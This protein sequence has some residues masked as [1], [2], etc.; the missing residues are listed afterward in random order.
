MTTYRVSRA[1]TLRLGDGAINVFD[2]Y[3]AKW[4]KTEAGG[5][6]LGRVYASGIVIELA[7]APTAADRA[8]AF[9]FDRSTRF[10]QAHVNKAWN[11]S[12]GEQIYLGEWHSHPTP[13]AKPS[14]RD[15][16]MIFNNLREARMEIDFLF[17]IVVGWAKDWVGIAKG[18]SL[19]Q[20]VRI[21]A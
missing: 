12:G 18:R 6:L 20:L 16:E 1:C 4:R 2:I 7:T 17:L 14:D 21:D 15:R 10:S 5:I 11:A 19:R 3:R 8:G 13:I 9:F